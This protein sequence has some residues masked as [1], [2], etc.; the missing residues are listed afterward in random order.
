MKTDKLIYYSLPF[1]IIAVISRSVE[2]V[3]FLYYAVPVLCLVYIIYYLVSVRNDK[4]RPASTYVGQGGQAQ[5]DRRSIIL[6]RVKDL[7]PGEKTVIL[8]IILAGI[9]FLITA[10]WSPYKERTIE[11][12]IYFL[13]IALGSVTAGMLGTRMNKDFSPAT[14][15]RNDRRSVIPNN[16]STEASA[17]AE[18]R[19]LSLRAYSSQLIAFPLLPANF[20]VILL[21]LFSLITGIPSDS[22]TL[23]NA[24]GFAGFFGH[25]NLLASVLLFT[26]P[27]VFAALVSVI[28]DQK[29]MDGKKI[30]FF[31]LNAYS[32]RL[33]AYC[34]LLTANLL[35]LTLTYSRAAMF[36]LAIGVIVYLV[37]MKHWKIILYSFLLILASGILTFSIPSLKTEVEKLAYKDF[38]TFFFTREWLWGPSYKAA[39]NG[40]LPGLGYGVSD[41]SIILGEG[42]GSHYE[43]DIYERE[44]GNSV[45]A[46]VEETGLIGLILFFLPI[47][48]ILIKTFRRVIPNS[49]RDLSLKD[50][51]FSPSNRNDKRGVIPFTT[52]QILL[53]TFLL[54]FLLHSQFEAWMVGV[55]SVQLPLFFFYA[56]MLVK[57]NQ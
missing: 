13:L 49:V 11:R 23:G 14:R 56:G 17:K 4:L 50:E 40:G 33:T 20:I 21:C 27:G 7:S 55:G 29:S 30:K 53:T 12:S 5:Y 1:F 52:Y 57:S 47:V 51:D 25:Q 31:Q 41:P 3:S 2:E 26:M 38:P 15:V 48:F 28:S 35:F 16:L 37:L 24:R 18:V 8:L 42:T 36:S 34:L 6:N 32:L 10:F 22:W 39:I 9:W 43:G 54:S 45:L 44:K 19:D 46:L